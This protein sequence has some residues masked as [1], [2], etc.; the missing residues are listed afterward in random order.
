MAKGK[1]A[2]AQAPSTKLISAKEAVVAAAS[3]FTDITGSTRGVVVEEIDQDED[4]LHWLVTLGYYE[5]EQGPISFGLPE[6]KYKVFKVNRYGGQVV[7]MKIRE[8]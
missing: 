4:N 7:S 8:V 5:G 6:R 3:Y 1:T 2:E